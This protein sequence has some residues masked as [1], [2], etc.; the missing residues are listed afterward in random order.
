M[1]RSGHVKDATSD[2]MKGEAMKMLIDEEREQGGLNP[3]DMSA[4]MQGRYLKLQYSTEV[5]ER[6]RGRGVKE[7]VLIPV[8]FVPLD[9]GELFIY[10]TTS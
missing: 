6:M 1:Y 3:N 2:Y 8:I 5:I 9:S 10:S 7:D 4:D